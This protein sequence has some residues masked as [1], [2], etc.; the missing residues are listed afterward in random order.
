LSIV[1]TG[2]PTYLRDYRSPAVSRDTS[3]YTY[4]A[5]SK[6]SK[7]PAKRQQTLQLGVQA[8]LRAKKQKLDAAATLAVYMT[9]CLFRLWEDK[10]F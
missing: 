6:S 8:I 5:I 10:Y 3:R 7:Q 1:Y 4:T 9:A 2:T